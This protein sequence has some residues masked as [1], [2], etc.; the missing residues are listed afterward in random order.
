MNMNA[1]VEELGAASCGRLNQS[2]LT[3]GGTACSLSIFLTV[4]CV[5]MLRVCV[6]HSHHHA[7]N[8]RYK[9][10]A[11]QHKEVM[12]HLQHKIEAITGVTPHGH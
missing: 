8:P 7:C 4:C 10:L 11:G 5:V 2:I 12:Q 9:E 3:R 6:S 1:N